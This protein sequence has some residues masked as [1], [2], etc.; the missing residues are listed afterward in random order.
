[1]FT[2]VFQDVPACERE[3]PDTIQF[4]NVWMLL[5]SEFTLLATVIL[6]FRYMAAA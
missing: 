6:T 3:I 4:R 2:V 1:M 5:S